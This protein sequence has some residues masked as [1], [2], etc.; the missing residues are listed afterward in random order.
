MVQLIEKQIEYT[1]C[2]A[3]PEIGDN[4]K[5]AGGDNA[6]LA[7][8]DGATLAGGDRAKLAGGDGAK[9]AGGDGAKLA[10]GNRAIVVGDHKSIAKGGKGSL[11]VLAERNERGEIICFKADIV[12]GAKIKSD[13]FYKLVNGE[14]VEVSS[15]K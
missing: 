9:L 11:L 15:E 4:A 1:R 8:G 13:T 12:D 2:A 14:F 5:L 10:G 7:G 6:T 3:Q